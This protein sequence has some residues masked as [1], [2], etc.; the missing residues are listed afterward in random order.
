MSGDHSGATAVDR[1]D[2]HRQVSQ[3]LARHDN[4]Y[5]GGRRRLVDVLADAGR[6]VTLPDIAGLSADLAQ[7]SVYRN[8]DVL[9]RSGVIR[10]IAIGAD[11]AH[12]ELAEPLI[13]HHHHLI[14][15]RCGAI[16]DIHL[17][18]HLEEQVDGALS[19]AAAEAGFTALHH[20]LDLHGH[21]A[22]CTI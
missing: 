4:R 14:C 1:E 16:E 8:L 5:T 22:N 2:L 13:A 21:C 12:F 11:H 19:S 20:S 10:R 15:I 6:P 9:E 7:S 17:P 3:R 18:D